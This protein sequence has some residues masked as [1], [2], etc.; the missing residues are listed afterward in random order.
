M[1]YH[2]LRVSGSCYGSSVINIVSVIYYLIVDEAHNL[3]GLLTQTSVDGMINP[4]LKH[5]GESPE[6]PIRKTKVQLQKQDIN[7]ILE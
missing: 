4:V 7:G 5:R 3:A 2:K 1:H 6:G